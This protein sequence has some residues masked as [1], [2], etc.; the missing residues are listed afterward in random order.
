MYVYPFDAHAT[1][2]M[3][4]RR[5]Q[6]RD[7]NPDQDPLHPVRAAANRTQERAQNDA[8]I[9]FKVSPRMANLFDLDP[10]SI[11]G[12]WYNMMKVT[13]DVDL[14]TNTR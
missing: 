4:D 7:G 12:S 3:E 10:S 8:T 11:G 6:D 1:V 9:T 13:M 14:S 2:R 5:H